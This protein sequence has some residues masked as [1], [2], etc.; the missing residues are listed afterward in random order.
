[1]RYVCHKKKEQKNNYSRF[2]PF[3]F[4]IPSCMHVLCALEVRVGSTRTYV[5]SKRL[6]DRQPS[7]FQPH[8]TPQQ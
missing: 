7:P 5:I 4:W 2:G 3:G 6:T 8:N 1:M